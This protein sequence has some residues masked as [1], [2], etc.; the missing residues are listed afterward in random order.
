MLAPAEA[1]GKFTLDVHGNLLNSAAVAEGIRLVAPGLVFFA[2]NKALINVLN[3]LQ[4]MRAYA[5]FRS[6]RFVLIPAFI[7][8]IAAMGLPDSYLALSLTLAEI[9]LFVGLVIFTYRWVVPLRP[10][11]HVCERLSEH[12]S[13]GL[14]GVLSGMLMELNTR[15]DVLMLGY[16][17]S[18]AQVGIFSFAAIMAEGSA[19]IPTAVRWNV[20][21]IIGSHFADGSTE[22]IAVLSR[23][24]RRFFYPTMLLIGLVAVIAYPWIYDLLAGGD[25]A[26]ESWWVFAIITAGV[27]IGAGYR[28][29]GGLLLQAGK[30]GLFTMFI[31]VLVLTNVLF[32]LL[33][34]PV[35][36]IYGAALATMLTFVGEAALLY[37]LARRLF[38]IKL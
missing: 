9:V 26:A 10:I 19:Q 37:G 29:F 35:L 11:A 4:W 34:I 6:I 16:F 2:L 31:L 3:G 27:V 22:Q 13:F 36:G 28:P 20:D 32:N 5:I 14:R 24:I 12:L 7:I 33:F 25:G 17:V 30:P 38:H 21:P 1:R 8:A 15:V 18:D 23:R